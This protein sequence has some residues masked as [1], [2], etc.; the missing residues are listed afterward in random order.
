MRN[1]VTAPRVW[2]LRSVN[3]VMGKPAYV[4]AH[5]R[6]RGPVLALPVSVKPSKWATDLTASGPELRGAKLILLIFSDWVERNVVRGP[7]AVSTKASY[8]KRNNNSL[9]FF[10]D[11]CSLR[12]YGTAV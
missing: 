2:L 7:E 12:Y 11:H 5:L 8:E 9:T 10:G 3:F 4:Y 1:P 6:R